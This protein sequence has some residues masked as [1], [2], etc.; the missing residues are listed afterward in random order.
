MIQ[1]LARIFIKN[2]KQTD[3]APVRRAY[4]VL[5]SG[6]GIC[7]NVLLFGGKY[8]A[9]TLSGSI[10]ITSDA[11]N[12][13]SDAASSIVTL[14]G[15]RLSARKP[16]ADHP[17]GHGRFEYLSALAV[18]M[19]ILLMGIELLK[20]AISRIASPKP[21]A[22]SLLTAVIL[23]VSVLVKGYMVV[24]NKKYGKALDSSAMRA[25]GTDSLSDCIATATV[26]M[27]SLVTYLF[28][29][30]VDG[31]C[32]LAVAGFILLSGYRTAC[33]AIAPL[34]GQAPSQELVDKI[35]A[36][37]CE[38]PRVFA[39]HDLIVHDYGPGRRMVSLH[40][41]VSAK[42]DM[43]SI[44][45]L[46]DNIEQRLATELDCPAVIHMDPV[47]TDTDAVA[48][49]L[50]SIRSRLT[51]IDPA[52]TLHDFRMVR[53]DTHTNLIFDLVVPYT[54]KMKA[55]ELKNRVAA[56]AKEVDPTYRTVIQIDRPFTR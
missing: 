23:L 35:E 54:Q 41:E 50:E 6:V 28:Q 49:V 27:S 46:I 7:L 12:N 3:N 37:V 13:L 56:L 15:F 25:A 19:T 44:H 17:F 40:A 33:D 5:C 48:F 42:E 8:L 51:E 43:E 16:D 2:W 14:L 22:F 34:L 47:H 52:L 21:P 11:F 4:G 29:I 55:E 36:L 26:L 24:Y 39:I 53:G 10:A 30:N 9:G 1:F 38:S 32:G 20:T 18:A 45:D 31:W